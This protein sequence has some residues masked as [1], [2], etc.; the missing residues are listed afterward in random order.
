[1]VAALLTAGALIT[2]SPQD[3]SFN[4][5]ASHQVTPRNLFGPFGAYISDVFFQLLGFSAFLLPMAMLWLGIK[6][7]RS[8]SVESQKAT[9]IGYALMLLSLPALLALVPFPDIRGA[10][11]AGGMTGNLL[12]GLLQSGFNFWGALIVTLAV[13]VTAAF[14][15]TTFSF[16]GAHAWA[17]SPRGPIGAV[18]RLGILQRAQARWREWRE[19][20]EQDRM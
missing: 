13:L 10:I 15:A 5:S 11:P 8:R 19:R 18:D 3:A 9:L 2:Y 17:N 16:G 12:A 20:R 7:F 4:V 6:W 1:M 14:L